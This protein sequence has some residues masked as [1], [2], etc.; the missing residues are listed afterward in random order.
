MEPVP[1]P[2]ETALRRLMLA[3]GFATID[4]A[5]AL[6][7]RPSQ[8]SAMLRGEAPFTDG[9]ADRLAAAFEFSA[10][11]RAYLGSALATTT[12]AGPEDDPVAAAFRAGLS[13]DL[14]ADERRL[15]LDRVADRDGDQDG[16]GERG[17]D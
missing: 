8:V 4:A 14:S 6:G 15:L 10:D 2:I 12:E 13:T 16:C 1:T 17:A 11:D 9:M 7:T 5:R 3:Y